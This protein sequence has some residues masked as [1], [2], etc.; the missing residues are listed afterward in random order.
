MAEFMAYDRKSAWRTPQGVKAGQAIADVNDLN[1]RA[2]VFRGFNQPQ[3]GF[4]IDWG[5]GKLAEA[6]QGNC[7]V[8]VRLSPP[9]DVTFTTVE[10][11]LAEVVSDA[12]EISSD[13]RRIKPYKAAVSALGLVWK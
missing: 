6:D 1:G 7:H 3:G 4:V 8:A 5:G 13:D 12:V 11:R 2:F 10:W 9:V